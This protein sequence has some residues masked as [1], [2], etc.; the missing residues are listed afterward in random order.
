MTGGFWPRMKKSYN[1]S[2]TMR[3]EMTRMQEENRKSQD[4][5]TLGN[6]TLILG[7]SSI[8]KNNS[9]QESKGQTSLKARLRV[10]ML[11]ES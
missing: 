7:K 10:E 5:R 2:Q 9:Q 4:S 11:K 6:N 3:M 1:L 8:I